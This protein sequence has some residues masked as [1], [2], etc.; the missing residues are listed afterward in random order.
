MSLTI[1]DIL[2]YA[3]IKRED[4]PL[5]DEKE[6][7]RIEKKLKAA[8]KLNNELSLDA[9]EKTI[10][11]L[12]NNLQEI[13]V[14]YSDDLLYHLF[15]RIKFK[16]NDFLTIYYL[17]DEAF[18]NMQSF[19]NKYVEEDL[20]AELKALFNQNKF[21]ML[22]KWQQI[23]NLL[24]LSFKINFHLFLKDKLIYIHEI[25]KKRP[26]NWVLH[27]KIPYAKKGDFYKLLNERE[28]IECDKIIYGILG[29]YSQNK[30][31]T[32][33]RDFTDALLHAMYK[34]KPTDI[35]LQ[36]SILATSYN[37][38]GSNRV[39]AIAIAC[40]LGFCFL[41]I[42]IFY[43]SSPASFS[44]TPRKYVTPQDEFFREHDK[45]NFKNHVIHRKKESR[46]YQGENCDSMILG[47]RIFGQHEPR[48]QKKSF[49]ISTKIDLK[50]GANLYKN[51][52]FDWT[53]VGSDSNVFIHNNT[54]QHVLI[55][56]YISTCYYKEQQHFY[57]CEYPFAFNK[58]YVKP[59]EALPLHYN[60]D[61]LAI[62][63]GTQLL[64]LQRNNVDYKPMQYRFCPVTEL[65]SMLQNTIFVN[66][67][68][69]D[70][71]NGIIK[72]D[73][74]PKNYAVTWKGMENTIFIDN[75]G[76]YLKPNEPFVIKKKKK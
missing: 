8:Q 17:K 22:L 11:A 65:D 69:K 76:N 38:A 26:N 54:K 66:R 55:W 30:N 6:I 15:H 68:P 21:K 58:V 12:K 20:L 29:F 46:V 27:S 36:S 70:A 51:G 9:V 3:D 61:S 53:I 7:I 64:Q 45:R 48:L 2:K 14:C 1:F 40:I 62:Q 35:R 31:Y 41:I 57:P 23:N 75:E 39:A 60:F 47:P 16:E 74:S 5:I 44:K 37:Y 43:L 19:L 13:K 4:T 32:V 67:F 25:L 72:L 24:P 34:Y 50:T 18:I 52:M 59:G 49:D 56:V 33:G 10:N 71:I 42:L 28:D 73:Q 63:T